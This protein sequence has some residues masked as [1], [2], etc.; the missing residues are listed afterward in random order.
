[1]RIS[2]CTDK[3]PDKINDA[4][5]KLVAFCVELKDKSMEISFEESNLRSVLFHVITPLYKGVSCLVAAA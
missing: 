2:F 3:P 5:V 4:C 1:M